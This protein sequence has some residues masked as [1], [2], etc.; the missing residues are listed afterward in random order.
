MAVVPAAAERHPHLAEARPAGHVR[1]DMH[2][3]TMWSGDATTTPDELVT[4]VQESAIDV[5][6]ITDHGTTNGAFELA[7]VLPCRVVVGQELRTWAG[8]IIGLFLTER[9][10]Y[11]AQPADAARR[12]RD[13]GGLV[14]IPHPF[15]PLRHCMEP[16]VLRELVD[17]GLV[18]ALEVFNAKTSLAHL[19]AE[20][21]E[22]AAEHGLPGGVGS[23]AHEPSAIGAAYIEMPDFDGPASFLTRLADGRVVGHFYD[24]ARAWTA[25]I[26]PS[27][28]AT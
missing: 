2:M 9:I 14:Y 22:F 15:D 24:R 8:E 1:V 13:Q 12:I 21:V 17:A 5:L 20:A 28:K 11:G 27:T 18:D 7:G 25:R 23:D 16:T 19:N 6:C 4:A 26:V 3:H 10:P